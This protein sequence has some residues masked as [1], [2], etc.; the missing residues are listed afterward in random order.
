MKEDPLLHF[1]ALCPDTASMEE[2]CMGSLPLGR[3]TV[4]HAEHDAVVG[5]LNAADLGILLRADDPV[6]R[7]ASPTKFAEYALT[8][9][10]VAMSAGIGDYSDL[11]LSEHAGFHVNDSR[12]EHSV[13]R[14]AAFMALWKF[15]DRKRWADSAL[16]NLSK[17]SRLADLIAEYQSLGAY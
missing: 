11:V 13:E 10:P 5:W 6:N 1:V 3:F 14:G 7:V 16:R 15:S 8:G 4:L 9:L 12:I 2:A 17:G